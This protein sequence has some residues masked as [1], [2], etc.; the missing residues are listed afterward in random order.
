M[1]ADLLDSQ[2]VD[3]WKA[4]LKGFKTDEIYFYFERLKNLQ[5]LG[6]KTLY[7]DY[8]HLIEAIIHF[9]HIANDEEEDSFNILRQLII[10]DTDRA[11][12]TLKQ[13]G[14]GLLQELNREYAD[15]VERTFRAEFMHAPIE[16]EIPAFNIEDTGKFMRTTGFVT[17][18]D[19]TSSTLVHSVAWQC[20]EGHYTETESV[21][22]KPTICKVNECGSRVFHI[23]DRQSKTEDFIRYKVQQRSDRTTEH[24]EPVSMEFETMGPDNVQYIKEKLKFGQYV[25]VSGIIRTRYGRR[26]SGQGKSLGDTYMEACY[27]ENLPESYLTAEDPTFQERVKFTITRENEEEDLAKAIRSMFPSVK[28]PENDIMK[29]LA[30]MQLVGSDPMIQPDGTR[31]RGE[32]Q[33]LIIG[34]PGIAKSRI[35]E[36]Y[37]QARNR[38]MY[39]SAGKSSS[40]G[41]VGGM[42]MDKDGRLQITSGVFGLAGNGIV[43]LDEFAGRPDSDYNDLLEP[44]SDAQSISIAKGGQYRKETVNTAVLAIANASTFSRYYDPTRSIYENTKIPPPNLQRF[45]A[46]IIRK[47]IPDDIEDEAKARHYLEM[48]SRSVTEQEFIRGGMA[49]VKHHGDTWYPVGF[50]RAWIAWLR[51]TFHPR[52]TDNPEANQTVINWYK[53]WRKFSITINKDNKIE[54]QEKGMTIPAADMRKLGSIIRFAQAHAR[55]CQ[56]DYVEIRDVERAILYIEITAAE[57][58]TWRQGDDGGRVYQKDELAEMHQRQVDLVAKQQ[59]R[60]FDNMI[61][62]LSWQKCGPCRGT[63]EFSEIGDTPGLTCVHCDGV[64]F[65]KMLFSQIDAISGLVDKRLIGRKAFDIIWDEKIKTGEIEQE[66]GRFRNTKPRH[67]YERA[68]KPVSAEELAKEAAREKIR[69]NRPHRRA[70]LIP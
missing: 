58:G 54:S 25:S 34:D 40:V 5:N 24:N 52:L 18:R 15:S 59:R 14:F 21:S 31:I 61:D 53:K 32:I 36:Y 60:I 47:D 65:E 38:V 39:N 66:G 35:A 62:A 23:D 43:I 12:D 45:D 9:K 6:L 51:E 67:V 29:E 8:D 19:A 11:R 2:I 56:R 63:G 10:Y 33:M 20:Q 1:S 46:I 26:V 17:E 28:L 50:V 44:M 42:K 49:N 30:L 57:A 4:F 16:K 70:D 68:T 27:I 48:Q 3:I 55:A 7:F 13:A 41:L 64:G 37:K 69:Q 22:A